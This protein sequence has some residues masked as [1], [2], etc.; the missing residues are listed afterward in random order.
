LMTRSQAA[1]EQALVDSFGIAASPAGMQEMRTDSNMVLV[2]GPDIGVT[3]P[4]A[5]YWLFWALRYREVKMVVVRPEHSYMCDRSDHWIPAPAG[6]EA[7]VLNAMA[8]IIIAEGLV[9]PGADVDALRRVVEG[10]DV[11]KVAAAAGVSV[12][13]LRTC[14][15]L[16]ATGGAGKQEGRTDY[17]ASTI[18]HTAA[19][20]D[21]GDAGAI[22]TAAHNLAI[23]TG[24]V[25][26]PGGGVLAGRRNANM[27][28]SFDVGCHPAI[29]PGG[30]LVSDA[31][32]RAALADLWR[33]RWAASV[34]PENGFAPVR[35]LPSEPGV[36]V[37]DLAA[38]IKSGQVRAMYISAQSHKWNKPLDGELLEALDQL[39][40]LIVED[41]FDSELTQRAHIVLPAAMFLEKDGSFTNL[42][43]TVQRLRFAVSAPGDSHPTTYY[44]AE[45]AQRLGYQFGYLNTAA[46]MDEIAAIL[47]EYAGISFPRLERNGMQWPVSS[48]GAVGTVRLSVGQGLVAD[49]IRIVAD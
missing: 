20:R 45:I 1:V 42:D 19:S 49:G 7:D 11:D 13:F 21:S 25:G 5:S 8:K 47:P 18:W 35:D 40:L 3:E 29:L 4:I 44:V 33:D 41:C 36:G 38:A 27:Q 46:I 6:A 9:A 16:Y 22:A 23:L 26:R 2:V 48:F 30:G 43:R 12:D 14:A 17:P 10:V 15:V 32:S 31:T 39:E 34:A 28:G 37:A 24:N